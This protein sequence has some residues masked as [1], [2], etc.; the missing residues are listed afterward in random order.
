M[1][2]S[3]IKLPAHAMSF[4]QW[5]AW[6]QQQVGGRYELYDGKVYMMSP[7]RV[8]HSRSKLSVTNALNRAIE[9]AGVS[10]EAIVDGPTV[11]IDET[12]GFEPDVIV[13]CGG[14]IPDDQMVAPNPVVLIEILS[15]TSRRIDTRIKL[16]EYFKLPSVCHYLIAAL[17]QQ[18]VVHHWRGVAD[19]IETAIVRAGDIV[20][21]PPGIT[22]DVAAFFPSLSTPA[23]NEQ[24]GG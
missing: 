23:P 14:R 20:L 4:D 22:I 1:A 9:L 24:G 6:A 11:K 17:E 21:E 3:A 8:G 15:P 7:E 13:N 16:T 19:R 18:T 2:E 10:C 12:K 5:L